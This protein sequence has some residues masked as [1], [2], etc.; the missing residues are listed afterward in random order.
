[1]NDMTEYVETL[2]RA[3][4]QHN[5]VVEPTGLIGG[6]EAEDDDLFL[7]YVNVAFCR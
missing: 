2:D 1:M 5:W 7:Y 3:A 4:K 6:S